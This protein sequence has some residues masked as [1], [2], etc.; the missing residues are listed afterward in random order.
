MSVT[1]F[2]MD[3]DTLIAELQAKTMEALNLPDM[4]P[5]DI[6]PDLPLF[7]AD[8]LGLDSVDALELVVM[9]E[10]EYGIS[11]DDKNDAKSAFST[12]GS[13]ADFILKKGGD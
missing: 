1:D 3:K 10:K 12:L 9:L 2:N 6:A 8:G 5:G 13:M 4:S 11:I 7:D